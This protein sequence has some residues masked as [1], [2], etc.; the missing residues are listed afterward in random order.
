MIQMRIKPGFMLTEVAG[1]VTAVPYGTEYEACGAIITLNSSGA[2]L[3]SMLSTDR[4]EGELIAALMKEY[5]IEESLAK[6]AV[7]LFTER[8]KEE[9]LL[10]NK[11]PEE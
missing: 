2:F 10:E 5:G 7:A 11:S 9:D 3:W 6:E 1:T 8:L 4:S